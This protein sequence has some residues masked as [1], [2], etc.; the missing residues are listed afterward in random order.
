VPSRIPYRWHIAVLIAVAITLS[1]FDRQ[2]LPVAIAAIQR[3]IPISNTA[4]SQLQAAFLIAY[5]AM[6][7]GGGKLLDLLGTRTGFL[8]IMLWWSLA[9]ASHGLA[10]G[11]GM[12]MASRFLLGMGEGGGFPAATKAVSEWFP[13]GERS[14]AMGIM[15]AGTALGA[16][17]APPFIAGVLSFTS[18]RWVFFLPG[19][20][21]LLWAIWWWKEYWPPPR[22]PRLSNAERTFLASEA[23]DTLSHPSGTSLPWLRLF[24]HR[25]VW[26][27]VG[28]KFL[29]DAGWYFYLFW[30]PKYLYDIRHFDI[31]QVGYSAWIPYAASGVGCLVGGWFSGWLIR[32]GQSVNFSRKLALG[33]SAA[34][35]PW[36]ILVTHLP[37]SL[38]IVLFSLAFFGQQSWST[39]IMVLPADLFPRSVVGSV[40]GLV[41]FGGAMGGVIF[42]LVVGYLLDHG[43]GYGSVFAI[44]ST[45]H[46]TAFV[47]ILITVGSIHPGPAR[48]TQSI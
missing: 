1:Y 5:A 42:G 14:L 26:G 12:L 10:T 27:L 6:Y 11:F 41:G 2:T 13:V 46:V 39:L 15:N 36:I 16:V 44:V 43:Y 4:F 31:K 22:H 33:L 37:V 21:G 3:D 29:S 20:L 7:A 32:R 45:L 25:E 28:A 23:A 34:V 18:W 35:M 19:V 48:S 8:F 47:L 40:A 17:I 9:C 24:T 38:A 30:F